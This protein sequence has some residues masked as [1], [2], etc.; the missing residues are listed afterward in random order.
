VA[1]DLL[2]YVVFDIL[3]GHS[4]DFGFDSPTKEST[5][6]EPWEHRFD[7]DPEKESSIDTC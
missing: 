6:P 4:L 5:S 3:E 2:K 7:P 1:L